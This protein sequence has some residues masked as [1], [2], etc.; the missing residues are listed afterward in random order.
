MSQILVLMNP[1]KE[2]SVM[3]H[4][5]WGDPIVFKLPKPPPA[6]KPY[7]PVETDDWSNCRQCGRRGYNNKCNC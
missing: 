7:R 5:D 4:D 6:Q 2:G 1:P 3:G